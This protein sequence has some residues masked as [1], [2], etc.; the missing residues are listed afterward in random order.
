MGYDSNVP[1]GEDY[2]AG[3]D[4]QVEP[5]R[6]SVLRSVHE[7]GGDA[8]GV[9]IAG[10]SQMRIDAALKLFRNMP[11]EDIERSRK[12]WHPDE[13]LDERTEDAGQQ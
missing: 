13:T 4:S 7:M 8:E 6:G 11:E 2:Q 12:R 3:K 1:D 10:A 9:I 5:S